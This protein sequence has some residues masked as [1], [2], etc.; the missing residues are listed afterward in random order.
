MA[1]EPTAPTVADA[2][3]SVEE[4]NIS[5]DAV[6]APAVAEATPAEG[7]S[8]ATEGVAEGK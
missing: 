1:D 6:A 3:K 2:T 7:G 8:I 4:V 5:D